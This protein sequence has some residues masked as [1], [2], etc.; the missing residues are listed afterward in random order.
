VKILVIGDVTS[1]RGVEH[2]EKRLWQIRD[3]YKIDLCIVNAENASFITGA[4]PDMAERILSAGADCLTGGNHTLRNKAAYSYLDSEDRML[5]PVNFGSEAPGSG[6]T[7][8]DCMG[9]RVLVISAMGTVY[10]DP[11]LNSPF[12]AIERVLA[13]ED[14]RY[15]IA[16]LDIHAEATGEKLAI[17]HAF[18]GKIQVIF[19]THTHVPTADE[20]ILPKGTGYIT[21]VGMCGESGGI[22]GMNAELVVARMRT[23]LPH[24]FE[25][26]SGEPVANG[27][28]F[29]ID[30]SKKRVTE[31]IRVKF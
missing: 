3:K 30:E 5:R 17:A 23:H 13:R 10:I 27:A 31:V 14:G 7:I 4:S 18:D 29:T 28:I 25:A 12:D 11:V 21:D 16:L 15:D 6:Y 20:Q 1:P 24:K 26:A 9:Y 19:G 2:L 8:L 22:L